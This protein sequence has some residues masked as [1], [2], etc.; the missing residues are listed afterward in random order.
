ML[1]KPAVAPTA[2]CFSGY[3]TVQSFSSTYVDLDK[4][5]ARNPI[6]VVFQCQDCV[7]ISGRMKMHAVTLPLSCLRVRSAATARTTFQ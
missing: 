2:Q 6:R 7:R 3:K 5:G 1:H 4:G